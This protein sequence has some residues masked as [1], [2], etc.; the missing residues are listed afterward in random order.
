MANRLGHR[1][2]TVV[3]LLLLVILFLLLWLTFRPGGIGTPA[4]PPAPPPSA[5]PPAIPDVLTPAS[6]SG[7]LQ[8]RLAGLP[9]DGSAP[10]KTVPAAVIWTDQGDEVLV[11]LS[12]LEISFSGSAALVSIDMESDQSGRTPMVVALALGDQPLAGGALLAA[13]DELPRGNALLAARWG[14]VLRDAAWNAFLTLAAD[15][16]S[17]TGLAPHALTLA[18][19][20]LRLTAGPAMKLG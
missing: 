18:N 6:L 11:H 10:G 5:P 14:A 15:H 17:Q 2:L 16:A 12:S 20:Q 9:A 8:T 13:T 1:M 19:G 7:L 4:Q 3:I